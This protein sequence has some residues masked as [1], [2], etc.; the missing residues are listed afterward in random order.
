M[1]SK[2][3]VLGGRAIFTIE[4]SAEYVSKMSA[5]QIKVQPHYTYKVNIKKE[6]L[7]PGAGPTRPNMFFVSL[8][9]GPDNTRD[10]SYLGKLNPGTGE[11]ALTKASA[12]NKETQPVIIVQRVLKCIWSA[13]TD[14]ITNAGWNV[15]HEGRCC[16]CAR[17]LTDPVSVTLGIGPECRKRLEN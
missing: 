12:F 11:V 13:E 3:F 5:K 7:K 15:H 17:L 16:K 4:P 9:T 6:H 1:I 14:N 8:L 10:Y 2:E